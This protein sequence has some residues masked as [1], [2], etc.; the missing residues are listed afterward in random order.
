MTK[1]KKVL[2]IIG[3][4]VLFIAV[5]VGLLA[6]TIFV[7][8]HVEVQNYKRDITAQVKEFNE[9]GKSGDMVRLKVV[10][11]GEL[12]NPEYGKVKELEYD[13]QKLYA[14]FVRYYIDKDDYETKTKAYNE[15]R[16]KGGYPENGEEL[17]RQQDELE[18]TM[19]ELN[20]EIGQL[21]EKFK[22]L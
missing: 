5:V 8:A 14:E 19:K 10:P 9:N 21:R 3:L 16:Q 15:A 11:F 2:K 7:Y 22:N 13:Y 1:G 6:T 12:I 4:S 18:K 17:S 20:E